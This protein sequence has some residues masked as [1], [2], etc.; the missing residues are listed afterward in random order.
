MKQLNAG[1]RSALRAR[2]HPLSPVVIIGN[3]G[4]TAGVLIEIERSLKAHEL[5]KIR[6]TGAGHA[7]RKSM[8]DAICANSSASPVQHIGKILVI[9]RE[10]ALDES[11]AAPR[12]PRANAAKPERRPKKQSFGRPSTKTTRSKSGSARPSRGARR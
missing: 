1:E 11:K 5:I 12:K 4:L 6:V 8:H 9:Y 10:H 2:A 3:D 7:E